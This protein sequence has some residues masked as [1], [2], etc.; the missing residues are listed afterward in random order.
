MTKITA[1]LLGE[2]I[3]ITIDDGDISIDTK[4][5]AILELIESTYSDLLA[6]YSPADGTM[7]GNLAQELTKMGAKILEVIEPPMEEDLVY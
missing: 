4:N 3:S 1:S 6:S 2:S 7:G 5:K